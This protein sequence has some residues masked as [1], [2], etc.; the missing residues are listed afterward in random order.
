[1]LKLETL[2]E[3]ERLLGFQTMVHVISLETIQL[4]IKIKKKDVFPDGFNSRIIKKFQ[5][6]NWSV[7]LED[8]RKI[9]DITFAAQE[10]EQREALVGLGGCVSKSL[11]EMLNFYSSEEVVEE[12]FPEE[13]I[14]NFN[15]RH[16]SR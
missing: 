15:G 10:F 8:C 2:K 12:K 16:S 7:S 5:R 14:S 6:A 13:S 4:S 3:L 11:E 9:L 1:M